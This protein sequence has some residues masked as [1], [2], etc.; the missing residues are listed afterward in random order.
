M[1]QARCSNGHIYDSD[2]YGNNCP[3]CERGATTID[4]E[5]AGSAA[6]KELEDIGKTE[7]VSTITPEVFGAT[8]PPKAYVQQQEELGK[9]M[10]AYGLK[11]GREPVVGWLVCVQG[12]DKGADYRL[13]P[14]I[15]TV[16]R[17]P[18][19]DVQIKGDETITSEAHARIAYAD[20]NN[21]FYL[22][23]GESLNVI[24]YNG[25]PIFNPQKLSAYDRITLGQSEVVFV[26]FCND[27]FVWPAADLTGK[28]G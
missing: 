16:G 21:E 11:N 19:N 5:R 28:N 4:F 25:A 20:K 24:Y 12:H 1:A 23:P 3:Y 10:P 13:F 8:T 14:R 18:K 15:N 17:G 9:T 26:P 27:R 22:V 6:E 2:I 7:P